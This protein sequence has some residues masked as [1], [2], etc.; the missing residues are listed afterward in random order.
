MN[1]FA[2][3]LVEN[4]VQCWG[5]G[6][7]DRLFQIISVAA[8]EIYGTFSQICV[9]LFVMLFAVFMVNAIWKNFQND[10]ADTLYEKSIQKVF[11]N[12]IV[13]IALMGMGVM[14]PR[15]LTT[16]TFEPVAQITLTYTQT[17]TQM[18][19]DAVEEKVT[20]QPEKMT[21]DGFF[22]PQLRDKIILLM[23]KTITQFQAYIKLGI[24]MMDQAFS[25]QALLG[26]GSLIKHI[27][28]FF[29][30]LYL[31]WGFFKLFF[32]YCCY[33]ADA[34][35]AMAFFAFFF[36]ISLVTFAFKGAEHVPE[37]IGKLGSGV[38]V[39]QIKNLINAIVTL[40]SVVL[41]YTV[42]M[43][44]IAKFF[45]A[46]D[47]S[48]A[49]L[50]NAITTGQIFEA[51]L[52]TENLQA[53]TFMSAIVLVYVLNYIQG[54]I[55]QITKMILAAFDVS[56]KKDMGEQLANDMITLVKDAV[57]TT[58]KIGKTIV[59]GGDKKDSK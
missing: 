39:N 30:G 41:T 37:W 38:G 36:P 9:V 26:P 51:D 10:F 13:A 6:V 59:S 18:D 21:E 42:I 27:I 57:D 14:L 50:M 7:F 35:V 53:M 31:A 44:I 5:C 11:I 58:V 49:D 48:A 25:W 54:Q 15:I 56:E 45:S 17:I 47:A 20:Y 4:A 34:I 28:L 33:F 2:S 12:G 46:P 3:S 1:N 43:V 55:P 29:I 23:K 19:T 8:A 16:I 24:A 40:G 32:R 22:R 52:N